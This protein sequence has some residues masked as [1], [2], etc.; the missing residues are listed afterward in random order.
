MSNLVNILRLDR[1]QII[2]LLENHEMFTAEEVKLAA[3]MKVKY[4]KQSS[5]GLSVLD[6]YRS[7]VN[8]YGSNC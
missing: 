1:G 8:M 7:D 3:K 4:D 2:E 5:R 6:R